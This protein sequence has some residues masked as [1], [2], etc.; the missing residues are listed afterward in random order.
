M[1][2]YTQEVDLMLQRGFP[3]DKAERI[4]LSQIRGKDPLVEYANKLYD[5]VLEQIKTQR[6]PKP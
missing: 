3:L 5:I 1:M 4:A 2:T 6:L